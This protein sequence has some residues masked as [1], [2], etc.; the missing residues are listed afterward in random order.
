MKIKDERKMIHDNGALSG[1]SIDA[2]CDRR[3][4]EGAGQMSNHN[5]LQNHEVAVLRSYDLPIQ[6]GSLLAYTATQQQ[7]PAD[8]RPANRRRDEP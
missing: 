4:P 5:E 3:A 2:S 7:W 6:A 1:A 8:R